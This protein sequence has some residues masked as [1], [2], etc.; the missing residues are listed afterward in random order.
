MGAL[1]RRLVF[2]AQGPVARPLQRSRWNSLAA[3]PLAARGCSLAKL[4]RQAF[5]LA[6]QGLRFVGQ[7]I[8]AA[9]GVHQHLQACRYSP[10]L[11]DVATH[12]GIAAG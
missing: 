5:A 12:D 9:A 10:P 4:G 2:K 3:A 1:W 11:R 6:P 7:R 8:G